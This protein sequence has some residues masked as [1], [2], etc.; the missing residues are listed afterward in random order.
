LKQEA[1]FKTMKDCNLPSQSS[2]WRLQREST[3]DKKEKHSGTNYPPKWCKGTGIW[4]Q[5]L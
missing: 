4:P 3:A 5:L 1:Q 2:S